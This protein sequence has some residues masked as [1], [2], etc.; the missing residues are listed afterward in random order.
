MQSRRLF[1]LV[2]RRLVLA[3]V[4]GL[5][6]ASV[7]YA[8]S[9]KSHVI[10]LDR[11]LDFRAMLA[12]YHDP[13]TESDFWDKK[14]WKSRMANWSKE[15]YRS[16][17]WLGPNELGANALGGGQ[18]LLRLDEFPE[19]KELSS[20][21]SERII[22]QM[23][24]LLRTAKEAGLDNF[25]YTHSVWVTP[26]F[27]KAH[28]IYGPMPESDTVSYFHNHQYGPAVYPECGVVNDDTKRYTSGVFAEFAQLYQDL[29]GFYTDI[30][31]CLP[32][33]KAA[34]FRDAIAPGLRRCGRKPKIVALQ[35]QVSLDSYLKNVAPKSVYDNVWLGFHGW[36]SEMITDARPYPGLVAWMESTELPTVAIVYPANVTQFPFNSPKLAYEITQ[37]MKKLKDFH[38]FVYW[39]FSRPELSPLFRKALG[40]YGK[41]PE[42]YSD[43]RWVKELI[44]N[45]GDKN[46]AKHF[47][48]AYNVSGRIIPEMCALVYGGSDWTKRELRIKYDLIRSSHWLTSPARGVMLIPI[49]VYARGEYVGSQ[50]GSIDDI[51]P[52]DHMNK[53][54]SMGE[55]CLHEAEE[56]MKTVPK[57]HMLEA[58]RAY[59]WMKGYQMLSKYYERKVAAGVYAMKY[60]H[61]RNAADKQQA[62]KAADEALAV[63]LEAADFW[64]KHLTPIMMEIYGQPMHE[65]IGNLTI[66]QLIESERSDRQ[67]IGQIFNW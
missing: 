39:E 23:K 7:G 30:G 42:P 25:L 3:L 62:E 60:A 8:G 1:Q 38:G 20:E 2:I 13:R 49:G 44:G 51:T 55:E 16:L 4:A 18:V 12:V 61:G 47:L 9:A 53:V 28:E 41:N 58:Q 54:K 46:A 24:W 40:Y 31:E 65:L 29:D 17:I 66:D 35:W 34:F 10:D 45:F 5:C 22:A 19:A 21:Q 36:N 52:F 33:D 63:Y 56:A 32:G 43:E 6:V 59:D 27:A 26:A 67:Q 64:Q 57:E 37:E 15:G 48:N 14:L 11:E 50:G